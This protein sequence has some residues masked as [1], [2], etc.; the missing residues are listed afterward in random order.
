MEVSAIPSVKNLKVL[1]IFWHHFPEKS[2]PVYTHT[3]T[4][5]KHLAGSPQNLTFFTN[6]LARDEL[7]EELVE[8][9]RVIRTSYNLDKQ[10]KNYFQRLRLFYEKVI[11]PLYLEIGKSDFVYQRPLSYSY[12]PLQVSSETASGGKERH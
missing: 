7:D 3:F 10:G 5:M 9:V 2:N 6:K 4:M 12:L 8:G 11:K 1:G